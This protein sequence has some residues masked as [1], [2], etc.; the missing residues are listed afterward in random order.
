[1]QPQSSAWPSGRLPEELELARFEGRRADLEDELVD[2]ETECATLRCDLHGFRARYLAVVGRRI[3]ELDRLDA[4]I[5]VIIA[6]RDPSPRAQREMQ[7]ALARAQ[8]SMDALGDDPCALAADADD[9]VISPELRKLFR[10]VAKAMHPD[11]AADE[12]ERR[13]R[14]RFMAKANRAYERGDLAGLQAILDEWNALPELVTGVGIGDALVR[15]I[16]AIA[17]V[18]ARLAAIAEEM[19]AL[20]TESLYVLFE[21]ACRARDDGRDLLR[22]MADE[23]DLRV[24]V[25]REKLTGLGL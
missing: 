19:T 13:L 2:R 22:E 21:R 24:A 8:Q 3:A 5:A 14:E 12:A 11:L 15:A 25:A 16:R 4:E 7:E 20:R 18:E 10:R 9:R 6:S 23:L 1:M 17:A